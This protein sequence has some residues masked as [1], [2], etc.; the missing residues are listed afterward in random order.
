MIVEIANIMQTYTVVS[1]DLKCNSDRIACRPPMEVHERCL[2]LG[3][4]SNCKPC[5]AEPV[6]AGTSA[7]QHC[8]GRHCALMIMSSLLPRYVGL[9]LQTIF[10]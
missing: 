5:S 9:P 4:A 10:W 1:E 8:L 7:D 2:E 3:S 6:A